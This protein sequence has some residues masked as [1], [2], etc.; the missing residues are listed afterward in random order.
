M[1]DQN[2]RGFGQV[3]VAIGAQEDFVL[4]VAVVKDSVRWSQVSLRRAHRRDVSLLRHLV[5]LDIRE[6][7]RI[8]KDV[9]I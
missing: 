9:G 6:K 5:I 8:V 2:A 7:L 1:C 3:I 4:A